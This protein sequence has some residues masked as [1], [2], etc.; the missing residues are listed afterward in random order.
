MPPKLI[1]RSTHARSAPAGSQCRF[2]S[3][4]ACPR[5]RG[6]VW[7]RGGEGGRGPSA[8]GAP[9]RGGARGEGG[10]RGR[11]AGPASWARG[12]APSPR[13]PPPARAA[14][15][16]EGREREPDEVVD[17]LVPCAGGG[18]GRG[19]RVHRIRRAHQGAGPPTASCDR[20]CGGLGGRAAGTAGSK[21]GG[22]HRLQR[23]RAV[24]RSGVFGGRSTGKDGRLP[25]KLP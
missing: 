1:S 17:E 13:W 14:R 19:L 18:G 3:L 21:R 7:D 16:D 25:S 2:I 5:A 11:G 6:C 20:G 24:R 4:C 15:L 8:A 23:R 9:V 12:R 22:R 10:A